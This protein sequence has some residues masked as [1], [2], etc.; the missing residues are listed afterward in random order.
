MGGLRKYLPVTHLT[1]L[2]AALSIAG[3]PGFAGFFSKDEILVATF[4]HSKLL[5]GMGITVAFLTAFYMFRLYFGIFWNKQREYKHTPHESPL[6][7]TLPL[8]VLAFLSIATG[9]IHFS[10]YVSPDKKGFEAHLNIP[11]ATIAV[12]MAVVGMGLAFL[13]YKKKTAWPDKI[14]DTLGSLYQWAYHKFYIDELYLFVTKEIIFKRVSTP[15]AWFDKHVVDGTMNLI[16]NSTVAGSEKIKGM[17]SGRIQDYAF[18]FLGGL[19]ILVIIV[20]YNLM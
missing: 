5:Y 20:V 4:E 9:Y 17:Q 15:F 12:T 3:F 7:M 16:G 1:F 18:A 19:V 14:S 2:I 6:A 10:E 13:F 8:M 11:L